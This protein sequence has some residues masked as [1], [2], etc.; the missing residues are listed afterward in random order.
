MR[1]ALILATLAL[2]GCVSSPP[3][4]STPSACSSL[5]PPECLA[6]VPSAPLPDGETVGDCIAF[7]DLQ[8]G[9]LDKANDRY[10]AGVGIVARCEKRDAEA[11]K[12]ARP[13]FLGI[14]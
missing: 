11:V 14:F 7:S 6:G 13:K 8:T 10:K 1:K 3:I 2:A 5:L 12:R 4:I 9:Q